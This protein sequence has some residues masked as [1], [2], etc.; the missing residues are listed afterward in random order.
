[1]S[2]PEVFSLVGQL[3]TT[4][5]V[6]IEASAGTGKTYTLAGLVVRYVAEADVSVEELLM[7]TF[8]RAAA[9]EL[10]DRVRTRLSAAAAA[11]RSPETI[12]ADDELLEFLAGT[13]RDL[14][15]DRLER[16]VADFDAATI[17]TIH[18]FAQHVL[19]TLG[20][21]AHIDLDATLLEDTNDLVS[22][23]CAD[24]LAAESV[25][26]PTTTDEL[27]TLEGLR[28]LG[29]KVLGNPGIRVIPDTGDESTVVAARLRRLVDRVVDEVHRRRRAAGT[30]SFD[31]MLT[32]LREGL[33]DP[34][35][36]AAVRRR[37][38]I[39]LIDEFQDTDPVQWD[40]FS[41]LF[42]NADDGSVLVLVGDPKQ[43]IYS[44]RGANVHTYLE[45]TGEPT[46]R[47]TLG[48]NRR[49]DGALLAAL[50][51]LFGGATFG[52]PRIEF[53]EVEP[54]SEHRGLRL[55]DDDG[56]ALGGTPAASGSWRRPPPFKARLDLQRRSRSRDRAR[57]RAPGPEAAGDGLDPLQGRRRAA[58]GATQRRCSAHR[59]AY[60]SRTDQDGA[61][62]EGRPSGGDPG[63]QRPELESGRPLALAPHRA[64]PPGRSD[65]GPHSRS[66]LVLRLVGCRARRSRRREAQRGARPG[67]QV[68]KDARGPRSGRVLR[69]HVV[70][71]RCHRPF[72]G[73]K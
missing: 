3:P 7:V 41:K 34:A 15:L 43:A 33:E 57:P 5:R 17:T 22:A 72:V 39:A 63:R 6:A 54:S 10:R 65:P 30:L 55:A 9:A 38:R 27:P 36:V 25:S 71:E 46:K 73:Y 66:L 59:Q 70:R 16:A 18:G 68:V 8:T 26:S 13:D 11:L 35:A 53:V 62:P 20:S 58:S 69:P 51:Q 32:Q 49:S 28:S 14:R 67:L 37:F 23:V 1:M 4:G 21:T 45:A 40:I 56:A 48:V 12:P 44:F 29:F 47:F 61:A 31:D 60:R 64:H 24:V 2:A 50:G 19:A 52:D 42:G